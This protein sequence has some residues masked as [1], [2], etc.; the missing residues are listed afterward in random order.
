MSAV[1][2]N[3]A[4]GNSVYPKSGARATPHEQQNKSG[5]MSVGSDLNQNQ[6]MSPNQDENIQDDG[7]SEE[8]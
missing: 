8:S 1:Q 3:S 5:V 7:E 2:S 4:A 6:Q